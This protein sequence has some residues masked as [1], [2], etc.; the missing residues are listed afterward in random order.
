M[1]MSHKTPGCSLGGRGLSRDP[2]LELGEG[3]TVT[4]AGLLLEAAPS[5]EQYEE[6]RKC[7]CVVLLMGLMWLELLD[8]SFGFPRRALRKKKREKGEQ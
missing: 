4:G 3:E 1:Q 5:L 7:I 6:K 2:W 8:Q